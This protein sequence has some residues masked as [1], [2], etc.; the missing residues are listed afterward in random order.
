MN[1]TKHEP[2]PWKLFP[3]AGILLWLCSACATLPKDFS[4]TPSHAI[5]PD[6]STTLQKFIAPSSEAHPGRS[7]FLV[8]DAAPD[9]FLARLAL[10]DMAEKTLDAQ[11]FIW[12]RDS[13]GIILMDRLY[14]A[15]DRGVRVRLLLDDTTSGG[16][17]WVL[18]ALN[19]HPNIEIR[20]FNPL[21]RRFK[22]GVSRTISMGL[23]VGRMTNRMH[24]KT[25]IVDNQFVIV[26][27][28]NIADEYFGLNQKANFR[29]MDLL[30][31]GPVAADVSTMFDGYWNSPWSIP[32]EAV[33]VKAPSP[34]S[35]EKKSRKFKAVLEKMMKNFP[36][37]LDFGKDDLIAR[38]NDLRSHFVWASSEVV[39]DDPG[40]SFEPRAPG[41]AASPIVNRLTQ[42]GAEAKKEILV[43]SPY[44]ILDQ[45]DYSPV[46]NRVRGGLTIKILTNSMASTD[47]LPVVA[48][49]KGQRPG[50]LAEGVHLYEYRDDAA[51]Q[52][53]VADPRNKARRGL[54]AKLTVFDRESVFVGTYNIDPRS[55]YLNTEVGLLVHSPELARQVADSVEKDLAPENSW[56]LSLDEKKKVLWVGE[57]DG[58]EVRFSKDPHTRFWKRFLAGFFS[59]LPIKGQL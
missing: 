17:D 32:L 9:A 31:G 29:D 47:A 58:E 38:L 3:L 30:G 26:G 11:Y 49:Y 6:T 5:P 40:K 19:A 4:A 52:R 54:H 15:A 10:A 23:H 41:A 46:G 56:R 39:G 37:P 18:G 21:G 45:T 36:I 1:L 55:Q 2:G 53:H 44:F 22:T 42:V 13:A 35:V 20:L 57:T 8:L 43:V 24:N 28:R 27:G 7:G 25:Y 48:M 14:R 59:F 33:G 34:A 16:K 51:S 50:L 12:N